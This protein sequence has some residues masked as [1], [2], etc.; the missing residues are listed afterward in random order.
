VLGLDALEVGDSVLNFP[1][2]LLEGGKDGLL[3]LDRHERDEGSEAVDD[4]VRLLKTEDVRN[5]GEFGGGNLSLRAKCGV[6]GG[7]VRS[8]SRENG[9]HLEV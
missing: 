6:K 4:R 5:G 1:L 7:A 8:N 2:T 9:V 3:R